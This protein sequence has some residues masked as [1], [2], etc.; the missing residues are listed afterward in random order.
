M[1]WGTSYY[2]VRKHGYTIVRT[3]PFVG[4]ALALAQ[5]RTQGLSPPPGPLPRGAGRRPSSGSPPD[6]AVPVGVW[7]LLR[8]A[9]YLRTIAIDE[10]LTRTDGT[11]TLH[12]LG[13]AL[14]GTLALTDATGTPTTAYT[15]APFGETNQ[16]RHPLGQSRPVHGTGERR[17]GLVLLPGAVRRARRASSRRPYKDMAPEARPVVQLKP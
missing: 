8:T 3:A 10:A 14:G 12:Y 7:T 1:Q 16:H 6:C 5:N 15:Y 4:K 17:D 9:Q 2:A 13:D 11:E